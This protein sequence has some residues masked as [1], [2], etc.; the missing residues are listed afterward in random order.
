[1]RFARDCLRFPPGFDGIHVLAAILTVRPASG[2]AHEIA[3]GNTAMIGRS[4]GNEVFLS[5][6]KTV[7]RQHAVI[8]HL[9]GRDY[10]IMDL[11]SR[12]GTFVDGSQVVLPVR[13]RENA[14]IVIEGN[15]MIFR[16]LPT[17]QYATAADVTVMHATSVSQGEVKERDVAILVCDIRGFSSYSETMAPAAMAKVLGSWCREA[18]NVVQETGGVI[19]KFIGDAVL[20]YWRDEPGDPESC[21]RALAAADKLLERAAERSWPEGE[22]AFRVGIALHHGSVSQEN[23]G[24]VAQRDATIIGDAVNVAFRLEGVMKSL[25]M[26]VVLSE[27]FRRRIEDGEGF[28]DHGEHGSEEG[29]NFRGSSS[30]DAS[31]SG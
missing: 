1:M 2:S 25:G 12:N 28:E 15:E 8:R 14:R 4:A 21:E 19:D 6:P 27:P 10:Q 18:A 7:S 31:W 23:I 24:V 13:L 11:G 16:S 17:T 9:G 26:R 29:W 3:V 20:A 30:S 5:E 22:P